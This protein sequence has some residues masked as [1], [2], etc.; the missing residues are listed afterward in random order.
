LP[1]HTTLSVAQFIVKENKSQFWNINL[2]GFIAHFLVQVISAHMGLIFKYSMISGD[3]KN[4]G[5]FEQ[6]A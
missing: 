6:H 2:I 1:S 5:V 3:D 4:E